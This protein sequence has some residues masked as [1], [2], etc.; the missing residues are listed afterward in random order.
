[1]PGSNKIFESTAQK[2]GPP[3]KKKLQIQKPALCRS[4]WCSRFHSLCS[5]FLGFHPP[6]KAWNCS[7]CSGKCPFCLANFTG[8]LHIIFLKLSFLKLFCHVRR[9]LRVVRVSVLHLIQVPGGGIQTWRRRWIQTFPWEMCWRSCLYWGHPSKC[10]QVLYQVVTLFCRR[11][12]WVPLSLSWESQPGQLSAEVGP[13]S[14]S[15]LKP[16]STLSF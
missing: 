1:M 13:C 8:L 4:A 3:F 2:P 10:S 5:A 14:E 6:V 7:C 11:R 9:E 16:P 15:L 12:V